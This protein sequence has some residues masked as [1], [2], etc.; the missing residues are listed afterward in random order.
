MDT[1]SPGDFFLWGK[2]IVMAREKDWTPAEY[3]SQ[4]A[5]F[6]HAHEAI[7]GVVCALT[8]EQRERMRKEA[9]AEYGRDKNHA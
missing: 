5:I 8:K 2:L 6:V 7:F 4:P 3:L 1:D 9:E